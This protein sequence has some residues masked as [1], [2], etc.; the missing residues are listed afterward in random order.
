[1]CDK[2]MTEPPTAVV[3]WLKYRAVTFYQTQVF[4]A[5]M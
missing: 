3:G 4:S 2:V 1:M 5:L